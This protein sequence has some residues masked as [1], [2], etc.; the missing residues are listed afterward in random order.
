VPSV[1]IVRNSSPTQLL[2]AEGVSV[3]SLVQP[4]RSFS[5]ETG[6]KKAP[7]FRVQ[8]QRVIETGHQTA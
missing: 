5:S 1:P 8:R 4:M 7:P 2:I 3:Q 6:G